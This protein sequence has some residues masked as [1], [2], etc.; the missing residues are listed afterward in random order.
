MNTTSIDSRPAINSGFHLASYLT[1]AHTVAQLPEDC[2]AEVAFAGR[3]N[4]GKSS[5]INALCRQKALARTSKTP[6]RTQQMVVFEL[7][8]DRRLVDLPGYGYAKVPARLRAHWGAELQ[9]YFNRRQSLRGLVI[10]MDVRHPMKPFDHDMLNFA[11]AAG[12]PCLAVLNK[13]DKL[14]RQQ[15]Q[16]NLRAV[17]SNVKAV[18]AGAETV[19][20]AALKRQGVDALAAQLVRWFEDGVEEFPK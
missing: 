4:S 2:G 1:S 8:H 7:D 12:L 15:A 3:S 10:V 20:L 17:N 18:H 11:G 13:A 16:R 14:S 6:G 5:T 9:R 19:L